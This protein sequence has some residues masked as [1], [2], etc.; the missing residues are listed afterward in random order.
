MKP[1][2]FKS[3]KFWLMI[4]DLVVSLIITVGGWYLAP[5]IMD[6]ILTSISDIKNLD[7]VTK[8]ASAMNVNLGLDDSIQVLQDVGKKIFKIVFQGWDE[9]ASGADYVKPVESGVNNANKN[10]LG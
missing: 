7:F 6:K 4:F 8:L 2:I 10:N 3:R 5:A 9:A 1:S